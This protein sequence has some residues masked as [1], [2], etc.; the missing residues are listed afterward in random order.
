[1]KAALPSRGCARKTGRCPPSR[2]ALDLRRAIRSCRA[3]GFPPHSQFLAELLTSA[4]VHLDLCTAE[5]GIEIL[6]GLGGFL[7]LVA[8]RLSRLEL[9]SDV[10]VTAVA[11]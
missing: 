8:G 10:S 1:M 4:P 3:K 7:R 11:Q 2:K 9:H 6:H 5:I